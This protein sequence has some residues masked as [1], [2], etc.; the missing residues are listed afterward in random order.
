M[1]DKIHTTVGVYIGDM[2]FKVN[3]V[4]DIDLKQHIA[5]NKQYRPGRALIVDGKVEHT[6]YFNDEDIP[7]LEEKF[8][9][10]ER[11][12]CTAPYV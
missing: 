3:G 10:C 11:S 7:M 2:S 8:K 12:I 5:Y 9:N 6:G 4:R 1:N